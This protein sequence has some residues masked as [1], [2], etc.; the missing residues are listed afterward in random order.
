MYSPIQ[1]YSSTHGYPPQQ[2]YPYQYQNHVLPPSLQGMAG[3]PGILLPPTAQFDW[4]S[5]PPYSS[6][7]N[8]YWS[9][10]PFH[11]NSIYQQ[12]TNPMSAGYL[13]VA[14]QTPT[15]FQSLASPQFPPMG[16]PLDSINTGWTHAAYAAPYAAPLPV[17]ASEIFQP[18]M[19]ARSASATP[20]PAYVAA[21]TESTSASQTA[22][23]GRLSAAVSPLTNEWP[24][25]GMPQLP[26]VQ[27]VP[28]LV[29]P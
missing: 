21:L 19:P 15:P 18:V 9:A 24:S 4:S 16:H 13:K 1:E 3:K 28:Y 5:H 26:G 8:P 20:A 14:P 27:D 17:H 10:S 22:A 25:N 2:P 29:Y 11:P 6:H 23:T 7:N 12:S